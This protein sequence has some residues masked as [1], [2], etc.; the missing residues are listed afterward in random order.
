MLPSSLWWSTINGR[1]LREACSL[2]AA[3]FYQFYFGVIENL[4]SSI[5]RLQI[6]GLPLNLKC[7]LLTKNFSFNKLMFP[8]VSP[9]VI[10]NPRPVSS[11]SFRQPWKLHKVLL[12]TLS[13]QTVTYQELDSWQLGLRCSS[14]RNRMWLS[15]WWQNM[16]KL[17]IY[18]VNFFHWVCDGEYYPLDRR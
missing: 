12:S 6:V 4:P 10:S 3:S 15:W 7:K 18:G 16:W 13:A 17:I 14:V 5:L 2:V 9:C 8:S 11:L 1:Y